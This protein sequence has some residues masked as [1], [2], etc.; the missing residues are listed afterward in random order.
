MKAL[1][2]LQP[3]A[4]MIA[5][6]VKLVENRIWQTKYR[7]PLVIHVGKSRQW[8][9]SED[10]AIWPVKY[11]VELPSENELEFGAFIAVA[12]L[13]DCVPIA[14]VD[15]RFAP[16]AFGPMCWV[17]E[18]VRRIEPIYCPGAQQ[19]WIPPRKIMPK[20]LAA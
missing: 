2:I 17:L 5:R 13:V 15:D 7:G 4:E 12:K 10:P 3:W 19:I 11:G 8:L 9:K 14:E 6:G 20:L 18:N 1:T 16:W